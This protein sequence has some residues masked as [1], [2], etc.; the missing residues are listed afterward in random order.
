METIRAPRPRCLPILSLLLAL[1]AFVLGGLLAF[2]VVNLL[3]NNQLDVYLSHS[4]VAAATIL[5][6]KEDL[7]PYHVIYGGALL[8]LVLTTFVAWM[9]SKTRSPVIRCSVALSVLTFVTVG[10][11]LLLSRG[12]GEPPVPPMTPTPLP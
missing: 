11:W 4:F 1:D 6:F 3:L 2:V 12:T 5:D 10:A 9:W 8:A 7:I